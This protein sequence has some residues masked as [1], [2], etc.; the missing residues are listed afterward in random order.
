MTN[1]VTPSFQK[2]SFSSPVPH[3][4]V[5]SE[6]FLIFLVWRAFSNNAGSGAHWLHVD[7]SQSSKKY[8]YCKSEIRIKL[9]WPN[10]QKINKKFHGHSETIRRWIIGPK[11]M[12]MKMGQWE[13]KN[14]MNEKMNEELTNIQV[15]LMQRKYPCGLR[16]GFQFSPTSFLTS[17]NEH[18]FGVSV[19][20]TKKAN[21]CIW[22]LFCVKQKPG[23]ILYPMPSS[24]FT[25]GS[26][27]VLPRKSRGS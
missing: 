19:T 13:N 15:H 8:I 10:F 23:S 24:L 9:T 27:F 18:C 25:I 12:L 21:K 7:S 5:K 2:F 4:Y 26:H 1:I 3:D 20:T 11:E 22:T 16:N 14:G 17:L 6:C